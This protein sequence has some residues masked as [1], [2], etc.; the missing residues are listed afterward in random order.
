MAVYDFL[1]VLT[2]AGDPQKK[3]FL[4]L[5]IIPCVFF[6][7]LRLQGAKT[8]AALAPQS[9]FWLPFFI[10]DNRFQAFFCSANN[11][12]NVFKR[13]KS[14]T[15]QKSRIEVMDRYKFEIS[16]KNYPNPA[17]CIFLKPKYEVLTKIVHVFR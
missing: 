15:L 1:K 7:G 5:I 4:N 17:L 2:R 12:I 13:V 14:K 6:K 11:M 3:K 9:S 16:S 10:A 8:N